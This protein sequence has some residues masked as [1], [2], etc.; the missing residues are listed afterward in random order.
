MQFPKLRQFKLA[1]IG[2]YITV[3]FSDHFHLVQMGSLGSEDFYLS[4]LCFSKCCFENYD[5]KDFYI[6]GLKK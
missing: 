4:T 5:H 6:L 1:A 3:E 2:S